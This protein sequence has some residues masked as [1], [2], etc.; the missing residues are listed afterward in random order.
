MAIPLVVQAQGLVADAENGDRII[1]DGDGGF[2]HLR[3]EKAVLDAFGERMALAAE[4]QRIYDSIR[5]EPARTQDGVT[6]ALHINAGLVSDVPRIAD[7]GAEGIGLYRTELM[8]MIRATMPGRDAQAR[9]YGSILDAA[10]GRRVVF[11]TLDIGSDKLLPY[12]RRVPEDNPALGWRAVRFG[13]DRPRLMRMQLQ[14]LLRGAGARPLTVMFPFVS[15]AFEFEQARAMLL[16]ERDRLA[17]RGS[18]VPEQLE[19]GAMLETPSLA[20]EHD[21]FFQSVDFLS[22]GG[23]DLQQFFFAAD[24][25]NEKVRRRY[26]VLSGPFLAFLRRIADRCEAHGTP[27]SFCGEAASRPLEALALSAIGFRALSMRPASVGPVKRL[28]RSADLGAARQVIESA[29]TECDEPV[30][31]A[32]TN[33][34]KGAGLPVS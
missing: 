26:D 20:Y 28:L 3:P 14:A 16:R 1:V 23:N 12:M 34:A 2:V 27:L 9:T 11:R 30:R 7:V 8:F 5:D 18:A 25:G 31:V 24:R 15:A 6:I 33:W 32:L 10:E 19:V 17:A 21:R 4:A 22:V 29:T 13:L